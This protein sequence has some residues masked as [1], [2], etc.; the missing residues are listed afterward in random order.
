MKTI[1]QNGKENQ[2]TEQGID[3]LG[4]GGT[5]ETMSR[6]KNNPVICSRYLKVKNAMYGILSVA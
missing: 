3:G 1:L 4:W 6:E 2:V 5:E